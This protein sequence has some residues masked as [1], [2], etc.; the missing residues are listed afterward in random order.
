MK[1]NLFALMA[2]AMV[3]ASCAKELQE[4]ETFTPEQQT[5]MTKLVRGSEGEII[6]GNLLIK[7]EEP[8]TKGLNSGDLAI[9]NH[10]EG[11]K[12]SHALPIQPKNME[13]ARKYGLHQWYSVEFDSQISPESM[14]SRLAQLKEVVAIQYN[15]HLEQITGGKG[16]EFEMPVMTRAEEEPVPESD[17]AELQA[18]L[19]ARGQSRN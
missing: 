13:V 10:I 16:V 2:A 18:H 12:I 3:C 15:R 4:V 17:A 6:P 1:K 7:I 11:I 19:R 5:L 8:A 9:F 14:A